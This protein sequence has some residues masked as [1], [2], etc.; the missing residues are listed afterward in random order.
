M[1][2]IADATARLSIA[3]K[4]GGV[5]HFEPN[6][7]Q[8]IYFDEIERQLHAGIPVR[9]INLKA[10]QIG[11]STA[12][13]AFIYLMSFVIP[14]TRGVIIANEIPNSQHLLSMT[15]TYWL[16]DPLAPLYHTKYASKNELHWVETNSS[17]KVTTAGNKDA[18]RSRTIQFLHASE[19]GFWLEAEK[20]MTGLAQAVP[21]LPRTFIA[22]ESTANGVGN[23]F[24]KTWNA[25]MAGDNEYVPLFFPWWTHYE[26]RG[27][28]VG[29]P[30]Y[31]MAPLDAE[32]QQLLLLFRLGLTVGR[33]HYQIPDSD[34]YDALA[35]RR[36]AIRN[37]CQSDLNKF[38]QEYPATP[39]EAFISTGTNVFPIDH[40]R[41]C[42]KPEAGRPGRLHRDGNR[43]TFQPDIAGPLRI[44]RQP[45]PDTDYGIYIIGADSTHGI[46]DRAV[47]QVLNRR[48]FEQVAVW[49][50]L[51]DPSHFAEEL[52]KLGT[53]FHNALLAPENEGPGFATIG[54]LIALEY[55]NLYQ[56]QMPEN[57]P[58]RFTGKFGFSSS[59]K[60][61]AHAISVTIKMLVDHE[62]TIHD[63][64]TF[65]E[66]RNYVTLPGGEFG[67]ASSDG[68]D[69]HVTSFC[70]A[71]LSNMLS[72]ILPA[73]GLA[74]VGGGG[75][76][77][78]PWESWGR[79][80]E[81][82]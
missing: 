50:G 66:M 36:W 72:G 39:E 61:K 67:P 34:W 77:E 40:L 11:I 58:G 76:E 29:I 45:S 14:N 30:T 69:D 81:G 47:A 80:Q 75:D 17:I 31:D 5:Q 68:Y 18:G 10:R 23:Y 53:Y 52:A 24:E 74:T 41:A 57:L 64:A 19:V 79:Q 25:A 63:R 12:T 48:T 65:E 27:S 15:E 70:I 62:L 60:T 73:Y 55:P 13:E 51:L 16:T 1:G 26:Y 38:H 56:S 20:V 54:G 21:S 46:H 42:F 4:S 82:W 6:W 37:L 22:L 2:F 35:W 59:Y 44:F 71:V 43:V 78:A 33:Q 9:T 8:V 3:V 49:K 7:A 28:Y 32:E